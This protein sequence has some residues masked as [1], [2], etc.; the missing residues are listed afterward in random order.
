[1]K[2]AEK[3]MQGKSCIKQEID[4]RLEPDVA[5]SE[6]TQAQAKLEKIFHEHQ[7]LPKKVAAHTNSFI[8][9]AAAIYLTLKEAVPDEAYDIMKVTMKEKSSKFGRSFSDA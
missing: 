6:W 9:P 4:R 2:N 7:D 3:I 1:M 8:F 5:K